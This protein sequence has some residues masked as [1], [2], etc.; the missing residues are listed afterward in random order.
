MGLDLLD[1]KI[2]YLLY[3]D[4]RMPVNT[5]SKALK[6]NKNTIN[7]RITR[8]RKNKIIENCLPV[9]D[10]K[11]LGTEVY[12]I[13]LKVKRDPKIVSELESFLKQDDFILWSVKT[14]GKWDYF[15][16]V[17]F[18]K[19]KE[20]QA[21]F[22]S[23][24]VKIKSI[25]VEYEIKFYHRFKAAHQLFNFDIKV[26]SKEIKKKINYKADLTDHKILRFFG[27]KDGFAT[28]KEIGGSL[29][30]SLETVRNRVIKLKKSGIIL[31]FIPF[32]QPKNAGL[33]GYL[34]LIK[35]SPSQ[36][37]KQF[38]SY[39]N[40]NY[41]VILGFKNFNNPEIMC[42]LFAENFR[43]LEK[44]IEEIRTIFKDLIDSITCLYISEELK[45]NTFPRYTY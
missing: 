33:E 35:F 12:D 13:L 37:L 26:P 41:R 6:A 20:F 43:E 27:T 38:Y 7:Y 15:F 2:I 28:Y 16:E 24:L 11:A 34:L 18:K 23:L 10:Y 4:A 19:Q 8:L 32:I 17:Y 44:I 5:I 1:K 40:N 45:L 36:D 42:Y 29:G 39:L 9:L 30:L 3:K 31:R 22:N 21:Y 14:T 25:I